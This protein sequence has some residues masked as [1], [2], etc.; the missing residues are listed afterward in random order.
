MVSSS[1]EARFFRSFIH[2]N[3]MLKAFGIDLQYSRDSRLTAN[4]WIIKTLSAFWLII[5]LQS[6]L[7][8]FY[9]RALKDL[10]IFMITAK[11]SS[12]QMDAFNG[13]I[14]C[15]Q[16]L[17]FFCLTHIFLIITG[18]STIKRIL[19]L[20]SVLDSQTGQ[21]DL[22]PSIRP[23]SLTAIVWIV[24]T[25]NH[26]SIS[27]AIQQVLIVVLFYLGRSTCN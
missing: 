13:F 11:T 19:E 5:N 22:A 21:P 8:L 20:I 4:R 18:P 17:V 23:Y 16:P 26:I 12:S 6:A 14:L 27:M 1:L 7:Y 24:L 25:V 9:T 2:F 3:F 15:T 10:R